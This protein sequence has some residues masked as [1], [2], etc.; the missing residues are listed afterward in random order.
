MRKKKSMK[1]SAL[2]DCEGMYGWIRLGVEG[3]DECGRRPAVELKASRKR[4]AT[5]SKISSG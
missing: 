4:K 1:W 3:R 5:G 2:S